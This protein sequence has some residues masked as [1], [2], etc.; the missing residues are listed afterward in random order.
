MDRECVTVVDEPI[1][2]YATSGSN[3]LNKSIVTWMG[4]KNCASVR[5]V[6]KMLKTEWN[7]MIP[8]YINLKYIYTKPQYTPHKNIYKVK[9]TH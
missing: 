2:S 4:L 6:I 8:L 9:D 7:N 1:D 3:R 5:T